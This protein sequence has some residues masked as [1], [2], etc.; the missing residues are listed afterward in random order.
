MH[1]ES[2]LLVKYSPYLHMRVTHTK[3]AQTQ[4]HCEAAVI[5]T[6]PFL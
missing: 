1:S 3:Y 5:D 6:E 2:P 4:Y